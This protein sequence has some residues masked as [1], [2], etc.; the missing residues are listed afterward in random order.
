MEVNIVNVKSTFVKGLF[1]A[2]Q[3]LT[4]VL[5]VVLWCGFL[6]S[7]NSFFSLILSIGA[8]FIIEKAIKIV[9]ERHFNRRIVGQ[10]LLS[11]ENVTITNKNGSI[12]R[13]F[14]TKNM[15]EFLIKPDHYLFHKN[16]HGIRNT[17]ITKILIKTNEADFEYT[18]LIT[19]ER[20]HAEF[21]KIVTN[22]NH[23]TLYNEI[24]IQ[25]SYKKSRG[26]KRNFLG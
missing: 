13:I 7:Y 10:M 15:L 21:L 19:N 1:R 11:K 26:L 12:T 9:I 18:C 22:Y 25:I 4:A 24:G 6:I 16:Y 23:K 3:I 17:G 2:E 20:Q 5:V 8:V 14:E